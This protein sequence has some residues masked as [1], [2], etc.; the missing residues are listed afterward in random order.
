MFDINLFSLILKYILINKNFSIQKMNQIFERLIA[1]KKLCGPIL[2]EK[3]ST[4]DTDKNNMKL[5]FTKS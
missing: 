4:S 2:F 1:M 5:S 3:F